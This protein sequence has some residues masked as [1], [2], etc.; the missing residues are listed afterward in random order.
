VGK[1]TCAATRAVLAAAQGG[2]VLVV[3]I[4]PAHSL[5]DALDRSLGGS[6]VRVSAAAG[7]L[8]ALELDA[9]AAVAR[10]LRR[11]RAALGRLLERGTYLDRQ[12]VTSLLQQAVPGVDE[13]AALLELLELISLKSTGGTETGAREHVP[14]KRA[15]GRKS[16]N[17]ERMSLA[18]AS[19][20]GPG[21][22][23][24]DLI[25][26]DT[27]PTGHTLRLLAMP[28]TA[29]RAADALHRL[30]D[31]E[32]ML[33]ETFGGGY[34]PD[35]GDRLVKALEADARRVTAVLSDPGHSSFHWVTLPEEMAVAETADGLAAIERLGL[36][37]AGFI[38]N[39][40]TPPP[41]GRCTF[42]ARRRQAEAAAVR[43]VRRMAG[44]RSVR[45]L[46]ERSTEPRGLR[47]LAAV[48]RS[49]EER[50]PVRLARARQLR[51]LRPPVRRRAKPGP[52]LPLTAGHRLIF[53]AGKGG[54]GKT[55]CAAA[56]ALALARRRP[57]AR[58]LLLSADPAHSL[59]DVLGQA[60][61]DSE[62][63]VARAPGGVRV[64]ELDAE[65]AFH[66]WRI[67]VAPA[68]DELALDEAT[69]LRR[70]GA[71]SDLLD[72][73]PPGIDEILA[74]LAVVDALFP[75]RHG[76]G[77][78]SHDADRGEQAGGYDV[79]V[80]DAAPTGHALRLLAWPAAAQSWTQALLRI[81]LKYRE[82]TGL[83]RLGEDLTRLSRALRRL[84][85][86]AA[87]PARTAVVAVTRAAALPVQETGRLLDGLDRLQLCCPAVLVN[88]LTPG[89]CGRCRR[90]RRVENRWVRQ[91]AARHTAP[92]R[93]LLT[94]PAAAPPPRGVG[95][96]EAWMESWEER[97]E[98]VAGRRPPAR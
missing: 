72:L 16:A 80:V 23:G 39:R 40:L 38:V 21:E 24:W 90:V 89:T 26:I 93:R 58:I 3:S 60:I 29:G 6:P 28:E 73:V 84:R 5:G 78:A 98:P 43:A 52:A 83:G 59:G 81:V 18:R 25:V 95:A 82:I 9:D 87:D 51:V 68:L 11:R 31:R 42:C 67:A 61:G 19:E 70:R 71:P 13:L 1:T 53:F 75:D 4:D 27:A 47:E 69:G 46:E 74:L 88:A 2:R 36:P 12:D 56:A 34:R 54:V 8:D 41:P 65:R 10:W 48:G 85:A 92:H 66:Q 7:R 55:T 50:P 96:L 15:G 22:G 86:L 57:G 20:S 91:L 77:R 76:A 63:G 35:A 37:L 79:V 33:A 49:L 64:R 32:R 17:R 44:R 97:A 14:P 94:T 62:R 45:L 30:G